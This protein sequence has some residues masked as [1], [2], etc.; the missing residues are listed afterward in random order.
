ME[1]TSFGYFFVYRQ[2]VADGIHNLLILLLRR[3]LGMENGLEVWCSGLP[4]V[5]LIT[6]D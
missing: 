6:H 4:L 5:S 1:S 2:T 3:N